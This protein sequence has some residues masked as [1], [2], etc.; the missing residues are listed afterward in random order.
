MTDIGKQFT[1]TLAPVGI[2]RSSL[3]TPIPPPTDDIIDPAEQKERVRVFR[4]K[5]KNI[6]AEIV[7]NQ[8]LEG[9]LEGIEG[10]SHVLVLFWPH[11]I[12][13]EKRTVRRVHPM[14]RKDFPKQ[15]VFATCSPARP[16]PVLVSAVE[17]VRRKAN[18][19]YVKG[20][21]AVDGTPVIDIKP[22]V[23]GYHRVEKSNVPDWMR[24]LHEEIEG[25]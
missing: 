14:G 12:S 2:V 19:L 5:L 17:L 20:L 18:V 6:V 8:D 25:D 11:L 24:R 13:S 22:Y 16:N 4:N 23:D 7:I 15:G 10:F 9:L 21:D 1:I 3:K